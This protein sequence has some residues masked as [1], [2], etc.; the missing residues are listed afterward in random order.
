MKRNFLR[1]IN[2]DSG[3]K[4]LLLK[5]LTRFFALKT[6]SVDFRNDFFII[7]LLKLEVLLAEFALFCYLRNFIF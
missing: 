2:F 7:F 6:G 1:D 4:S 5:P 3:A